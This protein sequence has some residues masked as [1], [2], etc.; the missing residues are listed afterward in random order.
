MKLLPKTGPVNMLPVL[1]LLACAA[2]LGQE[3]DHGGQTTP[4]FSSHDP[5]EVTIEAPIETLMTERPDEE[6]LDGLFS[7]T[8]NDGQTQSIDLKIR[9]RGNFRRMEESC[10][11][12]PIRLNF[13]KKQVE[14]TVFAGQDKLKLVTHCR[15][16]APYFEQLLLREYLAYRL[17]NVLTENSF[18]VRLLHITYIDTD[19]AKQLTKY[20]FVIEDKDD[21]A[22]RLGMTI[23]NSGDITHDQLNP[24][25]ATLVNLYQYMIGNTDFS[26]VKGEPGEECCHNSELMSATGD[27]PFTPLPYD[28]DFAGIVNA[29]YAQANP[30]FNL[31]SVRQRLYRGSCRTNDL[32]PETIQYFIDNRASLY[33]IV[34]E[35]TMLSSRSRKDVPTYLNAF[36]RDVANPKFV[37]DRLIGKCNDI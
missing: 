31:H 7:F 12:T 10:D 20:G 35:I 36:F 22:A 14:D 37:D 13:K 17:L 29:P 26:M 6:Y 5:L 2:V 18:N 1:F 11:F 32:L 23:V 30:N 4:L 21:V 33:A 16:N 15:S 27:A 24:R 25:Q 28:F 9:T 19:A 8:G 3:D 34:D